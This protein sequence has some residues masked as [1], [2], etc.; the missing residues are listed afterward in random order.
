VS[1]LDCYVLVAASLLYWDGALAKYPLHDAQLKSAL[2]HRVMWPWFFGR[3]LWGASIRVATWVSQ[4]CSRAPKEC[5]A[6]ERG[7]I[8]CCCHPMTGDCVP[9]GRRGW[10]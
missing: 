8:A 1:A 3:W 5:K 9:C 2:L 7:D 4:K 10:K 6:E